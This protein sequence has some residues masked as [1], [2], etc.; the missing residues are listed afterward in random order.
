MLLCVAASLVGREFDAQI[1][2]LLFY[3]VAMVIVM[4]TDYVSVMMD[5]QER[6][7]KPRAPPKP[8]VAI[9]QVPEGA[10]GA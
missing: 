7:A 5:M 6:I 9:V 10:H 8:I 2:F 4:A 1:V 3:V